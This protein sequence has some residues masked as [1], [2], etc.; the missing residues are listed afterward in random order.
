MQLASHLG[1]PGQAD[2]RWLGRIG[3][4]AAFVSNDPNGARLGEIATLNQPRRSKRE[5]RAPARVAVV[6][7]IFYLSK[8][9]MRS[10]T[11]NALAS[12]LEK[13][14]HLLPRS[15]NEAPKW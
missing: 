14:N 13:A 9:L 6:A 11:F 5:D 12:N 1:R 15:F 10:I 7:V 8:S 4:E 3:H 2:F